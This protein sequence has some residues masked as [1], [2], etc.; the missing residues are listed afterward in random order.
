V[1]DMAQDDSV[2]PPD[3]S[4]LLTFDFDALSI[5]LSQMN[6]QDAGTLSRGEFGAR[7]GADR[8]LRLLE[9]FDIHSTWFIPGHTIDTFPEVCSRIVEA[10]HDIQHHGYAHEPLEGLDP[11]TE[12]R[13]LEMGI[14]AIE[15]LTGRAPIGYRSPS[16]NLNEHSPHLLE[17]H[18]FEFASSLMATDFEI[19]WLRAGDTTDANQRFVFGRPTSIV[20]VPV[21]WSLDDFPPFTFVW[22]PLRPGYGST[23]AIERDWLDHVDYALEHTPGG[24]VTITMHPQVTGRAHVLRMVERVIGAITDRSGAKFTTVSNAVRHAKDRDL[25]RTLI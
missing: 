19:Y 9:Q 7:V 21:S 13:Y 11:A 8:V 6:S 16:W 10:G 4:I 17:S 3:V 2:A 23:E 24:V 15:R 20:E 22:D 1:T 14:E 25:V 12:A 18:N 5:W